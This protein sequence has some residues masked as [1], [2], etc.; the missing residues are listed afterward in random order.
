MTRRSTTMDGSDTGPLFEFEILKD[1]FADR[2]GPL[3]VEYW[4]WEF[5]PEQITNADAVINK[6]VEKALVLTNT[7][8]D[9]PTGLAKLRSI[10]G[11]KQKCRIADLLNELKVEML[12]PYF[13]TG[14]EQSPALRDVAARYGEE[15][16]DAPQ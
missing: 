1:E 13:G 4:N 6:L 2:H 10:A 3:R 15:S 8:A 5:G 11:H 16:A 7:I 14:W 12:L 9:L